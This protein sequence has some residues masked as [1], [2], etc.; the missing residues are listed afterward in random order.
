[1]KCFRESTDPDLLARATQDLISAFNTDGINDFSA[2]W[3][4]IA[5]WDRMIFRGGTENTEVS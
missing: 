3:L 1:M 2:S 5:T 4:F